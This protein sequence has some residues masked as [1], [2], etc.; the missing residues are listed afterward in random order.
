LRVKALIAT[1]TL[2]LI[3]LLRGAYEK[4]ERPPMA[5]YRGDISTF[6]VDGPRQWLGGWAFPIGGLILSPGVTAHLDPFE[7]Q[8]LR[9]RMETVIE[10]IIRKWVADHN[11]Q[12]LPPVPQQI[13]RT[14][15]DPIAKA[16]IAAWIA[17]QQAATAAPNDRPDKIDESV[18]RSSTTGAPLAP[19]QED[20]GTL[21]VPPEP[22]NN[23]TL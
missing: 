11:L 4:D 9:E 15:A 17:Q 5:I 22:S 12:A 10:E 13:D 23:T 3:L 6:R 8:E 2:V 7:A 16:K 18:E 19:S 1:S 14:T 20:L 21:Y